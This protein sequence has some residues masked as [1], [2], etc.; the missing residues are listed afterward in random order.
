MRIVKINGCIYWICAHTSVCQTVFDLIICEVMHTVTDHLRSTRGS[1][2][3][4]CDCDSVHRGFTGQAGRCP[5]P[6]SPQKASKVGDPPDLLVLTNTR[7]LVHSCDM[8]TISV[9]GICFVFKPQF[10][11]M[12]SDKEGTRELWFQNYPLNIPVNLISKHHHEQVPGAGHEQPSPV[13][14]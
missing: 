7:P 4:T 9:L 5:A 8:E 13:T 11:F 6:P 14:V 1:N 3:F 10:Q 2:V 12:S